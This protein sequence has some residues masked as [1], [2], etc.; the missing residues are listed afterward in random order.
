MY[1]YGVVRTA[2][3][4]SDARVFEGDRKTIILPAYPVNYRASSALY[5]TFSGVAYPVEKIPKGALLFVAGRIV[6]RTT[7]KDGKKVTY[8]LT[9][10]VNEIKQLSGGSTPNETEEVNSDDDEEEI[11]F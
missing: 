4:G 10:Y 6:P 9:L 8:G 11:P 1:F 3:A 2:C 5:L 7:E